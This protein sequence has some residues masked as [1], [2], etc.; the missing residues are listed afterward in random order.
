VL[1]VVLLPTPG[2]LAAAAIADDEVPSAAAAAAAAAAASRLLRS[3]PTGRGGDIITPDE[4]TTPGKASAPAPVIV[5]LAA[6][7]TAAARCGGEEVGEE[8]AVGG[9]LRG[10][11]PKGLEAAL[12]LRRRADDGG[13]LADGTGMGDAAEELDPSPLFLGDDASFAASPSSS[14]VVASVSGACCSAL[15]W[16][17]APCGCAFSCTCSTCSRA[18]SGSSR[19]QRSSDPD[20]AT[21]SCRFDELGSSGAGATGVPAVDAAPSVGHASGPPIGEGGDG[22]SDFDDFRAPAPLLP[23]ACSAEEA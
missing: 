2:L 4:G 13:L 22:G 5:E 12:A 9:G 10:A 8:A 16:L 14:A 19:G 15:E 11:V 3:K 20:A 17:D 18:R 6:A 21:A 1:L 23:N 7:S